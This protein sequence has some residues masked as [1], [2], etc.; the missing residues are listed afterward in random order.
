MSLLVLASLSSVCY[1]EHRCW[2]LL[3]V[4]T[5]KYGTGRSWLTHCRCSDPCNRYSLVHPSACASCHCCS[6]LCGWHRQTPCSSACSCRLLPP[7]SVRRAW[8]EIPEV[9]ASDDVYCG[10]QCRFHLVCSVSFSWHL[11]LWQE[12]FPGYF[13]HGIDTNRSTPWSAHTST[14]CM[15]YLYVEVD[16]HAGRGEKTAF[17]AR[18]LCKLSA[19]YFFRS[20]IR[21]P[22]WAFS[23]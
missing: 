18:T 14:P 15:A 4:I 9:S 20:C 5:W 17:A 7:R 10:A 12:F 11:G 21:S 6:I 3:H 23:G 2:S 19:L 8:R 1:Q 13:N 16:C 22:S